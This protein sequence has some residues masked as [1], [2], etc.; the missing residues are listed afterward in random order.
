LPGEQ[1]PR[2]KPLTANDFIYLLLFAQAEPNHAPNQPGFVRGLIISKE[3][4]G[5]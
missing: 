4:A 2:W 1:P 3:K 5:D